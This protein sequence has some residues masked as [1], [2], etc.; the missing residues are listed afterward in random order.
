MT[1]IVSLIVSTLVGQVT[2]LSSSMTSVTKL[3]EVGIFYKCYNNYNPWTRINSVQGY[4]IP[5]DSSGI[6][7]IIIKDYNTQALNYV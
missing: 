4:P 6:R 3:G 5:N 1:I 7:V 2:F